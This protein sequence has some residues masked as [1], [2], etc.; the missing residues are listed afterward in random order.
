MVHHRLRVVII[1]SVDQ[2]PPGQV[3]Y[4]LLRS[5]RSIRLVGRSL[6]LGQ[7]LEEA[8]SVA[9]VAPVNVAGSCGYTGKI[10]VSVC[11]T[12]LEGDCGGCVVIETIEHLGG[13]D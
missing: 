11:G 7:D 8:L 12:I 13:R 2:C 1:V 3:A 4:S 5:R 10:V 6:E 9:D